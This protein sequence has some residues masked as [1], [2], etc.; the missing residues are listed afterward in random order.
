MKN[1]IKAITLTVILAFGSTFAMGGI[2]LGGKSETGCQVDENTGIILG[3]RALIGDLLEAIGGIIL[4]GR[5]EKETTK[6]DPCTEKGGILVSDRTGIMVSDRSG[7][8]VS[9]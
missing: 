3:G 9:D 4:G 2:I 6:F 7:I 8:L 1:T 5:A